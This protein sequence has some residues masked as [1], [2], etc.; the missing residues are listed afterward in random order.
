MKTPLTDKILLLY[1][2]VWQTYNNLYR[3]NMQRKNFYETVFWNHF[4]D[5]GVQYQF[6]AFQKFANRYFDIERYINCAHTLEDIKFIKVE[7]SEFL[8][9]SDLFYKCIYCYI[10]AVYRSLN[11]TFSELANEIISGLKE[12]GI[13]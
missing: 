1:Q 12:E 13:E 4:H 8:V 11:K 6:L 9:C 3:L 10:P 7:L 2:T 5:D